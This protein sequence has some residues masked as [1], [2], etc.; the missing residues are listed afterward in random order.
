MKCRGDA[1]W[2]FVSFVDLQVHTLARWKLLVVA[3][4]SW[5]PI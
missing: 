5:R 1:N 2:R 4:A 3:V